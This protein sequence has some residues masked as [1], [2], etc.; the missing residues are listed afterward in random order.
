MMIIV[1][2]HSLYFLHKIIGCALEFD[3]DQNLL[4]QNFFHYRNERFLR[5]ANWEQIISEYCEQI[6]LSRNLL[7]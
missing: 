5:I 4:D 1:L 7:G 3:F 6:K 2:G